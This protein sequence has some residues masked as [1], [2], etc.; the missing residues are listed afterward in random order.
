LYWYNVEYKH[1]CI[2][3]VSPQLGQCGEDHAI[4]AAR[5]ALYIEAK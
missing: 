4:L 1:S 3:Y 5:Y 2:C